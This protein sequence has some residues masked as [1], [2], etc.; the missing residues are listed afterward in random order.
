[1]AEDSWNEL[2]VTLA[3]ADLQKLLNI[4]P[5]TVSR[6]LKAGTI[7][8]H[9]IGTTWITFRCDVTTWLASTANTATGAPAPDPHP[10]EAY[11]P[12]LT[13]SDLETLVGK[14]R[15]VINQWL[16]DG[17]IPAYRVGTLWLIEKTAVQEVLRSTATHSPAAP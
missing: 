5:A 17:T 7:P 10:L 13:P 2:P 6:W 9:R 15:P 16:K 3:T 11:P 4:R 12:L 1:M 14:R 8:S